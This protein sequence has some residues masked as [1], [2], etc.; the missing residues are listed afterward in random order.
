MLKTTGEKDPATNR[1]RLT[2]N[3]LVEM[4]RA[5]DN[6]RVPSDVPQTGALPRPCE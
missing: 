3:D 6:L 1:L 4:K 2:V 5:L